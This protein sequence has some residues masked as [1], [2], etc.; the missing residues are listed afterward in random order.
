[1]KFSARPLAAL[2][3]CCVLSFPAAA[4]SGSA[5]QAERFM[6]AL[7]QQ[8]F[9]DAAAM[10]GR[11]DAEARTA[12]AAQ[13]QGIAARIGGFSTMRKLVS[14]PSGSTRMLEVPQN[15]SRQL[16]PIRSRQLVY[17][18]TAA[19]GQPIFYVLALVDGPAPQPALWFQVHLPVPDAPSRQR[20]EQALAGIR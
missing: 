11:A 3:A 6:Q 4:D 2:A 10:F 19:D 14:L 1:M 15:A 13:L 18:A 12:S 7:Q 9:D 5:M 20:A 8:R 17:R 16:G